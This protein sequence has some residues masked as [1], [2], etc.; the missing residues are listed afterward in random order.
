MYTRLLAEA[1]TLF[2]PDTKD[3]TFQIYNRGFYKL[4]VPYFFP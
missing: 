1:T 3:A 2:R 4:S